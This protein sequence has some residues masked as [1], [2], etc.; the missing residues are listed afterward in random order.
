[1]V[2]KIWKKEQLLEV[3]N[4]LS[5]LIKYTDICNNICS[6]EIIGIANNYIDILNNNYGADRN[7]DTSL[8]GWIA[9]II[10]ESIEKVRKE[11]TEFLD[12]YSLDR[13]LTE[14]RESICACDKHTQWIL[15][16]YIVSSDFG[17]V[18]LFP[19]KK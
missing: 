19:E 14:L 13:E 16:I 15:E 7:P 18:L 11:Y 10:D 2:L 17:Y 3:E 5:E 12:K 8:G 4:K 6:K 1:M 9:I